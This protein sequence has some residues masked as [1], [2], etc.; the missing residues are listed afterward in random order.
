MAGEFA[1]QVTGGQAVIDVMSTSGLTPPASIY[2]STDKT[3]QQMWALATQVGQQL[4]D[5]FDWQALGRDYTITTDGVTLD[6]ALPA[7]F[8]GFY[9]DSSWNRTSRLPL[10][11]SLQQYEWQM[12]QARSLGG[13]TV[14]MMYQVS[15]DVV[16]FYSV[17]TTAQT[18]VLPYM[19]RAWV[20]MADGVT[21]R[22]NLSLDDDVVRYDPQLFKAALKLAWF[23]SRG[24][25]TAA[26]T[27]EYT[28]CLN[29]A[30]SKDAPGRAMTLNRRV[31][32]NNLL[33]VLNIP[34]TGYG[35]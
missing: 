27:A 24:F 5:E 23:S 11:G 21:Y 19:S 34:D 14:A 16:E 13:T 1:R 8:N 30:Q 15:N 4:M 32:S 33:G 22:D 6:Y 3:A 9:S 12:L 18:L 20:V 10:I 2:D 26:V 29:A 17:G 7:D 35:N 31:P 28:R 25:D